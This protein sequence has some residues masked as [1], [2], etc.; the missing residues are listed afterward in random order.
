MR[1]YFI[2]ICSNNA[3]LFSKII[4]NSIIVGVFVVIAH[5]RIVLLVNKV[6]VVI[7]IVVVIV[8][9]IVVHII[10]KPLPLYHYFVTQ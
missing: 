4:V 6:V 9:H 1:F 2:F 5:K 8:A 10:I 7:A 3:S